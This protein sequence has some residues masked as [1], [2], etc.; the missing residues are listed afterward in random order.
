MK[1]KDQQARILVGV[2]GSPAAQAAVE[3]AAEEATRQQRPLHLVHGFGGPLSGP[4]V[5]LDSP[6]EGLVRSRVRSDAEQ[7]LGEAV[8]RAR[9]ASP[10]LEVTTELVAGGAAAALLGEA[11]GGAKMVVLGSR[12]M[13][14]FR[15]LLVGSVSAEVASHAPC[16]VV[17]VRPREEGAAEPS[18]TTGRVVVGMDGSDVSALAVEFAFETAARRGL[19]LTA[20][21]AWELPAGS[22]PWLV[23]AASRMEDEERQAV[24][25]SLSRWQRQ[26]P[27]VDARPQVVNGHAA[28]ALVTASAGAELVV[29]GSR[30]RGGFAGLLLGSVS[31]TVLQHASCPV[32]V[33]RPHG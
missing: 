10:G 32:A 3:W 24:T 12:G 5:S 1:S 11:R 9:S 7:V 15:G 4:P 2:D 17:V 14:G 31:Q 27:D 20:L 13:G 33:V 28:H 26:F 25:D 30:G 16:P 18:A 22:S 8:A 19:G 21:R 29:V 6:D 23:T